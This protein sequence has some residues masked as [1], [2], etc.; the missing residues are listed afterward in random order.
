MIFQSIAVPLACSTLKSN[1][2]CQKFGNLTLLK[3]I[4]PSMA[5]PKPE[6]PKPKFRVLSDPSLVY[7]DVD[8]L[9][10]SLIWS[11][12]YGKSSLLHDFRSF[13]NYVVRTCSGMLLP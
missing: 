12:R 6:K 1:Q 10:I 5:L 7:D 9:R 3:P 4:S 2:I 8:R 11:R 13:R